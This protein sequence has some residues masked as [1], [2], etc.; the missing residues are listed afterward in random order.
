MSCV[1]LAQAERVKEDLFQNALAD[2][3]AGPD[4]YR[5]VP[6]RQMKVQFFLG[7]GV[8]TLSDSDPCVCVR[9]RSRGPR[10]F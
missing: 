9:T 4:A 10:P 6:R 7:G 1:A 8:N 3:V 5:E 2:V